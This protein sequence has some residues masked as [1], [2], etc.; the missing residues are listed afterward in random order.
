V[1]DYSSLS[2]QELTVLLKEGD[3]AAYAKIYDRY[4]GLLYTYACKITKDEDEAADIVQEVFI[5]LWDK[6]ADIYFIKSIA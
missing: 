6:R 1:P 2:D 3:H 5:Y 4:Q